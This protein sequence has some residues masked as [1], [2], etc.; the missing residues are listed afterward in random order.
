MKKY[1]VK[2]GWIA[3]RL[4]VGALVLLMPPYA[5]SSSQ[6]LL[7][8]NSGVIPL[9]SLTATSANRTLMTASAT[10]I[11]GAYVVVK[12]EIL[13]SAGVYD[14]VES[15][16]SVEMN[17]TFR[18]KTVVSIEGTIPGETAVMTCN[19]ITG[20]EKH[21][22]SGSDR[23]VAHA[24]MGGSHVDNRIEVSDNSPQGHRIDI[25]VSYI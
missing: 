13:K 19:I 20:L 17:Q 4:L 15:D 6:P 21:D 16:G 12:Y 18:H 25:D 8:V 23:T 10:F 9:K 5:I 2:G 22:C 24:F 7:S 1:G 11:A 3:G 14:I